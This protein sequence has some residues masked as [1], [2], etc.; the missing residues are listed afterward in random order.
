VLAMSSPKFFV[1]L[2][3]CRSNAAFYCGRLLNRREDAWVIAIP[4][5]AHMVESQAPVSSNSSLVSPLYEP[6]IGAEKT[7][8][9][10]AATPAP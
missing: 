5:A 9:S 6:R 2:A 8:R 1:V 7:P 3:S 4:P 10:G